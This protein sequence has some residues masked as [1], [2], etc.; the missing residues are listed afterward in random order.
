MRALAADPDGRPLEEPVAY[1]WT[2]SG[3]VGA[4][5]PP[6]GEGGAGDRMVLTAAAEPAEGLLKVV[7]RAGGREASAE[8]PVEVLEELLSSRQ[9]S[10][11][12]PEPEFVHQPGTPWRSR[13]LD[14]RW[15]VNSGHR[16]FR[17]IDEQPALKLRYLAM[18]FAKE[19]VLRSHQDPRLDRPL[20]QLVEV[21]AYADRNLAL[22]RRGRRRSQKSA[23]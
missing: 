1:A 12:I 10:E 17:A 21:A 9:S 8:A 14:G 5:G 22:K 18:L 23:D 13:M 20:E 19:V 7:A 2:L 3:P 4:L 16:E 15:Q 6:E 11:G